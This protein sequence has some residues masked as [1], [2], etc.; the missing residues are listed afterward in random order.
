MAKLTTDSDI[1]AL[2]S[3]VEVLEGLTPRI[4]R[5]TLVYLAD[6]FMAD[7]DE[8]PDADKGDQPEL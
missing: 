3:C 7:D 2:A 8:M 6:R 4:R 5:A 1:I